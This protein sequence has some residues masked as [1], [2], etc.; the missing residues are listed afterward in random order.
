MSK[1]KTGLRSL[2]IP[3][4]TGGLLPVY[5]LYLNC[6]KMNPMFRIICEIYRLHTGIRNHIWYGIQAAEQR[7]SS[8]IK[9]SFIGKEIKL[10]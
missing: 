3:A 7:K 2:L 4:G 9:L 5:F 10:I 1:R 6:K 8:L